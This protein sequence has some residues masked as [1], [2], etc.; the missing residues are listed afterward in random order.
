MKLCNGYAILRTSA[1]NGHTYWQV[2]AMFRGRYS[3]V[4]EGITRA[5]ALRYCHEHGMKAT[6][7][8]RYDRLANVSF[9]KT[10]AKRPVD[11]STI[12]IGTV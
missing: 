4:F 5:E 11:E 2:Y 10:H 9:R 7:A 1:R 3:L 8:N 6:T 12:F